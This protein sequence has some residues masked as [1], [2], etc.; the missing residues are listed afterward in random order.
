[1][2]TEVIEEASFHRAEPY[3]QNYKLRRHAVLCD[4]V[5][6]IYP[7]E[8][9]F[10][11]APSATLVNGY[12]GGHRAPRHLDDDL[13]QLSLP[14]EAAQTLRTLVDRRHDASSP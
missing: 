7:T 5:R 12:V 10:I 1:L 2:T 4:A 11:D 8:E 6:Q 9:A 3:H 13:P 14:K